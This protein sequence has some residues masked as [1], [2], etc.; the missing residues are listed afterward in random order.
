MNRP[1]TSV[2][3][4]S[5]SRSDAVLLTRSRAGTR[6]CGPRRMSCCL[7]WRHV[8][9]QSRRSRSTQRDTVL[10]GALS[11]PG[12]RR[13]GPLVACL[14]AYQTHLTFHDSDDLF[15]LLALPIQ[16]A[17]RC[18]AEAQAV[19][20][21]VCAAV[22]YDKYVDVSS[23]RACRLPVGLLQIAHEGRPSKRRFFLN[24]QTKYQP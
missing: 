23:Q 5:L 9:P 6:P 16:G 8:S 3:Y 14:T 7:R 19:S 24:W 21:I 1:R 11:W 13:E 22:S 12:R 4:F 17:Y 15:D 2:E 18:G 10:L 20:R